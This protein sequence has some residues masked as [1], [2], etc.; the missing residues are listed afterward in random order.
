[1]GVREFLETLKFCDSTDI[2]SYDD[3]DVILKYNITLEE[4]R[5]Y[6]KNIKKL[7]IEKRKRLEE[8]RGLEKSGESKIIHDLCII[9]NN[10]NDKSVL[11][12]YEKFIKRLLEI[13]S[14]CEIENLGR[15]KENV[16][17]E[18][19]DN[20]EAL[21]VWTLDDMVARY[22]IIDNKKIKLKG[23]SDGSI[24]IN[25]KWTDYKGIFL[26]K[27]GKAVYVIDDIE[28]IKKLLEIKDYDYVI[29]GGKPDTN[30]IGSYLDKLY[31]T[32]KEYMWVLGLVDVPTEKEIC[33]KLRKYTRFNIQNIIPNFDNIYKLEIND[34]LR[35][36]WSICNDTEE[37]A[38][39]EGKWKKEI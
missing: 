38:R 29:L 8:T 16:L 23:D 35:F 39:G 22:F 2:L 21:K 34:I 17:L 11:Y 30:E 19:G 28:L 37:K 31:L 12:E 18:C 33:K 14:Y 10:S 15:Q 27:E 36:T 6:L 32:N 5:T 20:F 25:D 26:P 24:I 4:L 7:F 3:I 13:R 9:L 1:M